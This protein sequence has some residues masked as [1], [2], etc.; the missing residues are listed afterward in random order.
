MTRLLA[1]RL[2]ALGDVIHTIPAVVALREALPDVEIGWVVESP[3]RELVSIVAGVEAIPVSMKRWGRSPLRFRREMRAARSAI[4]TYEVAVDFQ[5]LIKSAA[6]AGFS[7]ARE[8]WGFDREAIRE[9]AALLFTN[10]RA[11]IDPSRHI[12]EQNLDLAAAVA[13]VPLL[14]M[15]EVDFTPFAADPDGSLAPFRGAVVLLPGAGKSEKQ[16]PAENFREVARL[17]GERSLVV[18]GPGEEDLASA[19]GAPM[20]PRT[21]LRQLAHVLAAARAVIGGDT[22]PLHLAAALG[23]PVVGLYGPTS[24][25]RNGPYGQ[26]G[27]C[28]ST[29]ESTRSMAD[30]AVKDVMKKVE[31]VL[32]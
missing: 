15:P 8:R 3:Y 32:A 19:I 6:L 30:I 20:A 24:P 26:I 21:N 25:R 22:G 9:K 5:G 28:V 17:I 31:E 29:F 1:I 14:P 4:R 27:R 11:A 12:V 7:R 10:R 16:W 23:R 13:G 18:W 2:S